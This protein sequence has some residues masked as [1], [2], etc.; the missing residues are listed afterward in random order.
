MQSS[1]SNRWLVQ[2]KRAQEERV[3]LICIHHAGAAASF[4][5]PWGI[6]L[7]AHASLSVVQLPGREERRD[8]PFEPSMSVVLDHVMAAVQS[9]VER[10]YV[11][12]GH[13]LGGCIAH[14]LSL[15]I[16]MADWPRPKLI[17]LSATRAPGSPMGAPTYDLP[18]KEFLERIQG[19][20]G[21]PNSV[22]ADRELLLWA[23]PRLR[24]DT[25]LNER[26][27]LTQGKRLEA[28]LTCFYGEDDPVCEARELEKWRAHT[29]AEFEAHGF[30]GGHF[31]LRESFRAIIGILLRRWSNAEPAE[32]RVHSGEIDV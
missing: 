5:R 27:S 3:H 19:F 12:F 2:L 16:Q 32:V 23:L 8:E 6:T 21:T 30:R 29:T 11:I 7:P 15:R 26:A 14:E 13:S 31:Y 28:P 1:S 18:D 10:P 20:G 4:F 22:V 17:G 25:E 24:A 9:L